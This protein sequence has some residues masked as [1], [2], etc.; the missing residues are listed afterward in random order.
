MRSLMLLAP[1]LLLAGC[2]LFRSGFIE[3]T[4]EDL[5]G[6]CGGI[7]TELPPDDTGDSDPYVP[8]SPYS[9]GV[10]TAF[11]GADGV[12]L[13][14]VDEERR[15]LQEGLIGAEHSVAPGPVAYDPLTQLLMVWDNA[16]DSLWVVDAAGDLSQIPP[17][18]AVGSEV[19]YVTDA[20]L[21]D[22]SLYLV[23]G[24]GLWLY[25]PGA[26]SV[27]LVEASSEGS[28]L[29][30][31]FFAFA[32]NLFLLD[33]GADGEP[34]LYRYTISEGSSRVSYEDFDDSLG[35][36]SWGF[37]GA[38][39]LPYVCSSVGGV[40]A[41]EALQSGD[42]APAAYPNQDDLAELFGGAAQLPG[43]TDCAW[44]PAAERYM[45]HSQAHGVVSMD[46]WGRLDAYMPPGPELQPL[47]ADF[48][49]PDPTDDRWDT[50][51]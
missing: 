10:A 29:H 22:G 42:R 27:T 39:A 48:F 24:S 40:Y 25:A 6:G 44:D 17:D 30:S 5:P 47:R 3:Q 43:V 28:L 32:D 4:C 51:S 49:V 12:H 36:S 9:L 21:V 26:T 20:A 19:G 34:D 35:R 50:G 8:V 37:Q 1:T 41:I 45:L 18:T 16:S 15:L 33:W 11:V 2:N 38:S 7:D 46:A 14:A 13:T 31:V 23:S